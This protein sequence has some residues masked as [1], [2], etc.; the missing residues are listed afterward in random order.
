MDSYKVRLIAGR[1]LMIPVLMMGV[2][3][4]AN[5]LVGNI[6]MSMV[7]LIAFLGVLAF[8]SWKLQ[9]TAIEVRDGR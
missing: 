7:L 5:A 8:A 6:D 3:A 2:P 1:L 4:L 9:T